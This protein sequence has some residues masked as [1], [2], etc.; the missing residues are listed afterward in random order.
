MEKIEEG[1]KRIKEGL[2]KL[3]SDNIED[4]EDVEE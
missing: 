3:T 4:I 2:E 1:F